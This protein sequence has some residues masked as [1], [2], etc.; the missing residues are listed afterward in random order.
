MA[1]KKK[2]RSYSK[3]GKRNRAAGSRFELKVRKDL[4]SQGYILDKWT[5]NVDFDPNGKGR[6]VPAKRKYNPFLRALSIGTGFPDFIAIKITK[7]GRGI[8][9]DI[10]GVEV[11]RRGYLSK[12]E[13]E[14]CRFY[15]KNTKLFSKILIAKAIKDGRRINIEYIDFKKKY[16]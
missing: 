6:I 2:K 5:N 11:K 3:Q 7:T 1:V 8:K 9:K 12:T 16:G 13:K 15:L 14:K 10:I 4:E